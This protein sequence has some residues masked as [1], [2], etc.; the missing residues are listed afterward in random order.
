VCPASCFPRVK[1]A[2]KQKACCSQMHRQEHEATPWPQAECA[3]NLCPQRHLAASCGSATTSPRPEQHEDSGAVPATMNHAPTRLLVRRTCPPK[4]MPSVLAFWG[5]MDCVIYTVVAP[6]ATQVRLDTSNAA[7]VVRNKLA[8]PSTLHT[9]AGVSRAEPCTHHS[10][11]DTATYQNYS[12]NPTAMFGAGACQC[13]TLLTWPCLSP[14]C[15]GTGWPCRLLRLLLCHR[16]W[17]EWGS[18]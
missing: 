12:H 8:L 2:Q 13:R 1:G 17:R 16:R 6:A 15:W 9:A 4:V 14:Y 3:T 7:A 5:M 11:A 18:G 10:Q